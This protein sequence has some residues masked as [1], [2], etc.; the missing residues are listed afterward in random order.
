MSEPL[1]RPFD[2]LSSLRNEVRAQTP[3]RLFHGRS[4]LG[5]RTVTQLELRADHAAARDAV[6]T[7]LNLERDFPAGFFTG[8]P[9][10]EATTRAGSRPQFLARPDLGRRLDPASRDVILQSCPRQPDV[11]IVIGDGLSSAAVIRQVPEVIPQLEA[12]I[13]GR[14]W[15]TGRLILVHRCR[16]GIMNEV[17]DLLSP[18]VVVLL[19]GERP[20]L[21]TAESLSAYLAYQP[22]EGD[23]DSRRNLISNIQARGT[24]PESA[25]VRVVDLIGRM[26]VDRISGCHLK[27]ESRNGLP[28]STV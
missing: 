19:I 15:T 3:A 22:R 25:A 26:L 9:V 24:S 28:D 16:V 27:E 18:R 5:Y 6:H 11:Q 8:R 4:G 10:V 1:P 12:L 13:A 14:G 21:A 20:G 17:G 7:E 2:A 23:T